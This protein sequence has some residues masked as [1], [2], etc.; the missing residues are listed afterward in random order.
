M[1]FLFGILNPRQLPFFLKSLEAL[2]YVDVLLAQ[3]MELVT[4]MTA[5][6]NG[7]LERD[8]DYLILT[9]DNVTIPYLGPYK[10]IRDVEETG[11]D[12]ITGW[13][14]IASRRIR[15]NIGHTRAADTADAVKKKRG[16]FPLKDMHLYTV[17][18]IE[19]MLGNGKRIIPI[20]FTG[21]SLTA[22]SRNVVEKWT[23]RGWVFQKT[24]KYKPA[25]HQGKRG[26]WCQADNWYS[27][28]VWKN[29]F[30]AYA[31]LTVRVPHTKTILSTLLVGKKPP[32]TKLIK[33]RKPVEKVRA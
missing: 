26:W 21:W 11:Y 31:D 2:D 25:V 29:G 19:E 24:A 13:S 27:Y 9:S 28:E 4:A 14:P 33:A 16:Y 32:G 5:I 17:Q 22:M 8:Y 15:A 3:N 1:K 18:Q 23:P 7:F 30:K 12:I 6:K 20:W 10:L